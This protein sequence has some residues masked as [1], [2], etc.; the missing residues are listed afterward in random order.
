MGQTIGSSVVIV[1]PSNLPTTLQQ[2]KSAPSTAERRDTGTS[3]EG[4]GFL[5]AFLSPLGAESDH[6]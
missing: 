2:N 6:V 4:Y 3:R 5:M 1:P